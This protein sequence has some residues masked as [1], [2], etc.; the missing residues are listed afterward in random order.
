[1]VAGTRSRRCRR[2][3]V[4]SQ[5]SAR[6]AAH[7]SVDLLRLSGGLGRPRHGEPEHRREPVDLDRHHRD[8]QSGL[9]AVARFHPRFRRMVHTAVRRFLHGRRPS[10]SGIVPG[11][12]RGL[13]AVSVAGDRRGALRR[14]LVRTCPPPVPPAGLALPGAANPVYYTTYGAF[15]C[16]SSGATYYFAATQLPATDFVSWQEQHD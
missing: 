15:P 3:L 16:N 1:M 14:S 13:D 5:P 2:L 4:R 6:L 10:V 9:P 8:G 12:R 11:I 7:H